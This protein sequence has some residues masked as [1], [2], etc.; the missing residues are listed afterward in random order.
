MSKRYDYIVVGAGSGGCAVAARLS[1]DRSMRVLLIEAGGSNRKLEVKAPLAFAKQF[2]TKLDWDYWTE[3]ESSLNGRRIFSPRGKMLGGCSSMNAMIYIRG[4]RL[5]YDTWAANGAEGWSYDDVL[6][7]FT[8]AERNEHIHD[9]YHGSAGPLNVTRIRDIDPVSSALV[10]AAANALHVPVN[11]DFNGSSQDGVGQFQ[12]TQRRGIRFSAREAYLR[13]RRRNLTIRTNTLVRKIVLDDGRATGVEVTDRKGNVE[14]ISAAR[15]VILA[16]GAFNTPALL[17]HSGI[18]PADHLRS[19]GVAP[20]VDLPAVG[21]HL[22]EHPLVYLT[23]ELR[24]GQ[25]GLFD[26][27]DARHLKNWLLRRRGKLASNVAEAGGHVRTDSSL[28]AP[29]FQVLFAP[30]FFYNHGAMAWDVPAA[31]IAMS[32]IAPHSRGRVRIRS[33][34][35]TRKPT[36]TYNMLATDSEMEEMVE[37]VELARRVAAASPAHKVLG[38]EITPGVEVQSR[39]DIAAW[40]RSSVEHTYHPSCSARIGSPADGVV[41]PQLRVHGVANLRIAD[42]SVMP[43]IIRG[44]TNATAIMIGERCADF[45]RADRAAPP[46]TV[47]RV[48]EVGAR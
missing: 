38:A 39:A 22:M 7:Y 3:P 8:R 44:N 15:E 43:T 47:G 24:E 27:E 36:V 21:E 11:D 18:G 6:P 20:I 10:D 17:Q 9:E 31:T 37:A 13:S 48:S 5:D 4:N 35:P 19:V 30:A 12:V 28:A 40:I 14:R 23:Y 45:V 32:Y 16:A 34:D 29:N 1:E 42:A 2:H 46:T 33:S 25:I 41:D 26:A